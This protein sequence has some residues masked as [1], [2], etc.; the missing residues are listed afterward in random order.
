M[1]VGT[2]FLFNFRKRYI[3]ELASSDFSTPEKRRKNLAF[4]KSWDERRRRKVHTLQ[5]TVRRLKMR[6]TSMQQLIDYLKEK[7]LISESSESTIKVWICFC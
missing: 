5:M 2:E 6:I 3:G 4:V 1:Y 7:S